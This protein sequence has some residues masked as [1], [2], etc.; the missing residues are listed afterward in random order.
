MTTG[1][2]ITAAGDCSG[3]GF[4]S[5]F[6]IDVDLFIDCVCVSTDLGLRGEGLDRVR[7]PIFSDLELGGDG[8]DCCR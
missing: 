5:E 6:E 7:A 2:D 3:A 1:L 8:G 4:G